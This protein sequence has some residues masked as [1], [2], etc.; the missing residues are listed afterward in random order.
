[1]KNGSA[2]NNEVYQ[3][4]TTQ[5][6]QIWA[7]LVNDTSYIF[8]NLLPFFRRGV[9][10]SPPNMAKRAANAS[11]P[12]PHSYAYSSDSGPLEVGSDACALPF[13]SWSKLAFEELGFHELEDFAS[14]KLLGRQYT[15][16][17]IAHDMTRSSSEASYLE[18]SF[19][20]GR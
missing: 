14:G 13:S 11:V 5:S 12:P 6:Y 3:H 15:P 16:Q 19:A 7:D 4:G 18:A 8:D 2:L 1:M 17:T 9:H 10:Y 20:S